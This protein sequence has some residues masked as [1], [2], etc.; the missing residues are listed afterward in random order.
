MLI[1]I[2]PMGPL[3]NGDTRGKQNL[4]VKSKDFPKPLLPPP[5]HYPL[6]SHAPLPGNWDSWLSIS[7][8]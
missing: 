2:C 5:F 1:S 6:F 8:P 4:G 7:F 3:T